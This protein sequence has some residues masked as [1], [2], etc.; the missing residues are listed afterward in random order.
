RILMKAFTTVSCS[1]PLLP[2]HTLN[3]A[4]QD[5]WVHIMLRNS[6]WNRTLRHLAERLLGAQPEPRIPMP[7]MKT[8]SPLSPRHA[9]H[10]LRYQLRKTPFSTK[11]WVHQFEYGGACC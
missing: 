1:G 5:L 8:S 10:S 9:A 7:P 6:L 2:P 11:P 4:L 3:P